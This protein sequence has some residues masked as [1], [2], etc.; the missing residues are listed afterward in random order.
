MV[1]YVKVSD[2]IHVLGPY[3]ISPPLSDRT[4]VLT[5]LLTLG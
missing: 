5:F 3:L 2:V 1:L 4:E